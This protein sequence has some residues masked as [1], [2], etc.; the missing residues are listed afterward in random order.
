MFGHALRVYTVL[1][2]GVA[3]GDTGGAA[4]GDASRDRY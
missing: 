2:P 1:E 3:G 4:G